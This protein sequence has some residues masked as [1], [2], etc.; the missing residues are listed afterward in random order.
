MSILADVIGGGLGKLVKEIV[1]TFKLDPAEKAELEAIVDQNA[2]EIQMKEYELTVKALDAEAGIVEAQ[3]SIIVAEMQQQDN[4]TKRA[5]PTVVYAGLL[6]IFLVHIILP[7]VSYFTKA[8]YP[9]IELPTDFWYVWGGV[10][11]VWFV[12]RTM[13]RKGSNSPAIKK[14]V[15]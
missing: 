3:K 15:G 7:Y 12:G 1:G 14:I 10:C 8:T 11:A 13:E 4:Y 5:R 6:A 9:E 2:H